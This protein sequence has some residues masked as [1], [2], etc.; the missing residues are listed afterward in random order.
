MYN[1]FKNAHCGFAHKK[2]MEKMYGTWL[3]RNDAMAH[4]IVETFKENPQEPIIMILG[5]GHVEH[6]MAVIDRVAHLNA[7]IKQLNLGFLEIAIKPTAL[8][9]YF[10]IEKE[11]QYKSPVNLEKLVSESIER[12]KH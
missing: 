11:G 9:D 3:E 5:K 2:M 7:S 12:P 6:N 1:K 4:S 10:H 8:D